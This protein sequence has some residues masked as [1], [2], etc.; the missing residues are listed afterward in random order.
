MYQIFCCHVL[1]L[2]MKSSMLYPGEP[3]DSEMVIRKSI[4]KGVKRKSPQSTNKNRKTAKTKTGTG[5]RG[6]PSKSKTINH[7]ESTSESF[8]N[9]GM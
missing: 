3:P 8:N 7:D 9:E 2:E 6:R 1:L 5:K 4:K